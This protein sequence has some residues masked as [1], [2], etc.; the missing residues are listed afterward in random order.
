[1]AFP[2]K[3]LNQGEH[4]VVSTR[5]HPKVLLLPLLI[6]VVTLA[7]AAFLQRLGDGNAAEIMHLA[8]WVVAGW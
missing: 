5:T 3:L 7:V 6:L 8:A 4:V 2:E 1:M